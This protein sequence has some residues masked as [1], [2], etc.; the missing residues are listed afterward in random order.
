MIVETIND[1][2]VDDPHKID[3]FD[4]TPANGFEKYWNDWWD[5]N[6][7]VKIVK[8]VVKYVVQ[9][10]GEIKSFVSFHAQEKVPKGFWTTAVLIKEKGF[11]SSNS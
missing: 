9:N 10:K 7:M 6:A 1:V 3:G 11:V 5:I 2:V 4:Q 8:P